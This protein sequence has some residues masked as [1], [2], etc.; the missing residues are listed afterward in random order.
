[1]TTGDLIKRFI[2]LRDYKEAA[3]RAFEETMKPY[4][5]AMKT[6]EDRVTADILA[7]GGE[8]IKTEHG[9]AYRTQ[10]MA[11]KMADR[12]AFMDFVN[13]DW[14]NRNGFLTS[15]VTKEMVK[16]YL[17]EHNQKPPGLDVAYVLKTNFRRA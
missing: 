14:V 6:I 3:T 1:M 17:E 7:C 15:A 16:E 10:V 5:E 8:S 12:E 11:V 2:E 9:T 4:T 13:E